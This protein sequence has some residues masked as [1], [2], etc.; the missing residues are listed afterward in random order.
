MQEIKNQM[1]IKHFQ[2]KE[3]ESQG[4]NKIENGRN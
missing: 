2:D 1:G 3:K 4:W